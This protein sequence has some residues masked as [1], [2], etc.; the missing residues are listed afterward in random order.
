M[1]R[2]DRYPIRDVRVL[3]LIVVAPLVLATLS[4]SQPAQK[5]ARLRLGRGEVGVGATSLAVS[6][7]G[8]LIA[9]TNTAG[10]LAL[11]AKDGDWQIERL[12][13]CPEF[14][15]A[16]A[17]SPDGRSLAAAGFWPSVC[18]W[19]LSSN[20]NEPTTTIAVRFWPAK[21]LTFSP[22]G[23]SLAVATED[24]GTILVMDLATRRER[25]VIHHHSSVSSIA[26]SPDGRLLATAGAGHDRLITVWDLESGSRRTL[27]ENA[28]GPDTAVAFSAN[29]ALLATASFPEHHVRLW[30][31]ETGRECRAF[32]GHERPVNALAFSPDGSMLATAGNDGMLGVWNVATG[33]R[34]ASLNAQARSLR[35]IAFSADGQTLVLA[36][37]DD[38][39]IR[40]WD[41]AEVLECARPM[42]PCENRD[43]EQLNTRTSHLSSGDAGDGRVRPIGCEG[44]RVA[45]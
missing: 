16:V 38:D 27:M 17:F 36:T 33:Q 43:I 22:D 5:P 8:A 13:D 30:D 29:G 21:C 2:S 4:D 9:T 15:R 1:M 20:S 45:N 42:R 32:V 19:D 7:T 12:L 39:D 34:R 35:A 26:F 14:A 41:V 28:A 11:R 37:Q 24:D 31:V 25:M 40:M 6:P 10:R 44:E 3:A 18:L 23:R